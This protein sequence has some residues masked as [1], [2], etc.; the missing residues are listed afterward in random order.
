MVEEVEKEGRMMLEEREEI[1]E[2]EEQME[3]QEVEINGL[4]LR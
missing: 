4:G 2:E 1:E 3:E